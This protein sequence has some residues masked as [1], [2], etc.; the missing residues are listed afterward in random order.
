[1]TN[2]V[3][4]VMD[5]KAAELAAKANIAHVHF[6]KHYWHDVKPSPLRN[7]TNVTNNYARMIQLHTNFVRALLYT[8]E[9]LDIV[10]T[11]G[12]PHDHGK[13]FHLNVVIQIALFL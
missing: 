7:S 2:W 10:V 1:M 5:E 3:A 4:V 8:Y 6:D 11:D 13:Q 9:E 12:G